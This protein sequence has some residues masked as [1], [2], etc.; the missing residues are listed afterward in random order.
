LEAIALMQLSDKNGDSQLSV[1]E[2]ISSAGIF[3]ASKVIDTETNFH[4]E[5]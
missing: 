2:I 5:F 3:L 4:D 1:D